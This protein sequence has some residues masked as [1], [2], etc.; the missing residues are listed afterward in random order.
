MISV[1]DPISL[2]FV[3]NIASLSF[4]ERAIPFRLS[5]G[6]FKKNLKLHIKSSDAVLKK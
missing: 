1:A 6:F 2:S 4:N 3:S 5:I